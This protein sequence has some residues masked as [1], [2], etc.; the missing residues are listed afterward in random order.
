MEQIVS[1]DPRFKILEDEIQRLLERYRGIS[2]TATLIIQLEDEGYLICGTLCPVC[3]V[4][5]MLQYIVDNR[6]NHFHINRI[7]E[8]DENDKKKVH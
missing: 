8:D 5:M 1:E 3:S 4:E 6:L 7:S 2:V